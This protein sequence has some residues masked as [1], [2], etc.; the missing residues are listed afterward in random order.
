LLEDVSLSS[1]AG[2]IANFSGGQDLSLFDVQT[3]LSSLQERTGPQT[4]I[5]FGVINDERMD[6]RAQVILMITGLGS[7][8]M[9][10]AL[11]GFNQSKAR[12]AAPANPTA[13]W[14]A[15][16]ISSPSSSTDSVRRNL[17][18]FFRPRLQDPF[19]R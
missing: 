9:E 16:P 1:A 14:E 13:D 6:G 11:P 3:A 15:A 18:P 2:V 8:T 19:S 17:P 10:E 12:S 4:E 7:S 5:V